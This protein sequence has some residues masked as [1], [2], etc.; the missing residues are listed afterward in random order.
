M[1]SADR[2]GIEL[3]RA[4]FPEMWILPEWRWKKVLSQL[5]EVNA[6]VRNVVKG[7]SFVW[8]K[9]TIYKELKE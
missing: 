5:Q 7:K 9:C 8:L 4:G 1:N 2:L 6:G 3:Y